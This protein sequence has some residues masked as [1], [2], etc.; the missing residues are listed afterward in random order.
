MAHFLDIDQFLASVQVDS[1]F[2]TS[3][4]ESTI[5]RWSYEGLNQVG[6]PKSI[7]KQEKIKIKD[8]KITKPQGFVGLKRIL[9]MKLSSSD[10]GLEILSS[11]KKIGGCYEPQYVDCISCCDSPVSCCPEY[12]VSEMTHSFYFSDSVEVFT[13]ALVEYYAAPLDENN[14]PMIPLSAEEAIRAYIDL[15]WLKRKRRMSMGKSTASRNNPVGVTD[16]RDALMYFEQKR[17]QA[18]AASIELSPS[19]LKQIGSYL[20]YDVLNTFPTKLNGC[21]ASFLKSHY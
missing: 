4:L 14:K 16:V 3:A 5:I 2:S 1:G 7:I 12:Q 9:L 19:K 18:Q 6:T 10:V 15:K 11:E 21:Y 13:H 17:T 8:L 20:R